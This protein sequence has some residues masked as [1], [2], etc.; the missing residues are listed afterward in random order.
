MAET[1]TPPTPVSASDFLQLNDT[2]FAQQFGIA[3]APVPVPEAV[4]VV[5]APDPVPL[6]VAPA[7]VAE[8]EATPEEPES[9]T[10][11]RPAPV[12]SP[13]PFSLYDEKGEVE[14]PTTL[15]LKYKANGKER[16]QSLE[17]VVRLAQMGHY[18]EEREQQVLQT[19]HEATAAR[20]RE[21]QAAQR[22]A[23]Y[24]TLMKRAFED[25]QFFLDARAQYETQHTPEA[26]A[27][28]AEAERDQVLFAQRAQQEYQHVATVVNQSL[29]P[30]LE[31][32]QASYPT[33]PMDELF[34]RFTLLTAPLLDNGRV[35]LPRLREVQSLMDRELAPWA[36]SL[37]EH[38]T[39]QSQASTHATTAARQATA[40][41]KR[42]LARTVAPQ[43][44]P[45]PAGPV[46]PTLPPSAS[47]QDQ[48]QAI[49]M[50]AGQAG[51]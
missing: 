19:R 22:A 51:R 23:Q 15:T 49:L 47:A 29:L 18:N 21:G 10:E 28:R 13:A 26:R 24:E 31:Q 9:V 46:V 35:P 4:P 30:A 17:Q 48:M 1:A 37:H 42:S 50:A 5:P 16:E 25:E 8:A 32:M 41:A 38:R 14:I 20:E 33:V 27:Q 36:Q 44:Q 7:P 12:A 40:L 34:G 43:G 2:D 11:E 45:A 39:S 3:A 6:A